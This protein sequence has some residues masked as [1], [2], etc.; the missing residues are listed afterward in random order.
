[1]SRAQT[2]GSRLQPSRTR[3]IRRLLEELA[4]F[5][6]VA[7]AHHD[8]RTPRVGR[9]ERATAGTDAFPVYDDVFAVLGLPLAQPLLVTLDPRGGVD[10]DELV[11]DPHFVGFSGERRGDERS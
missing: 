7:L 5:V 6:W 4:Q 8:G 10:D 3:R 11:A 1:M 9:S 2:R